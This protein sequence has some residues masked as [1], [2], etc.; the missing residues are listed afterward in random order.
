MEDELSH[1]SEE[2]DS[3]FDETSCNQTIK[4]RFQNK[5]YQGTNI[6]RMGDSGNDCKDSLTCTPTRVTNEQI[7]FDSLE[8]K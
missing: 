1:I 2:I 3:R 6:S 8:D 5:F 4:S 7:L